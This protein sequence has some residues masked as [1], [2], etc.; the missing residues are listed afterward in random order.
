MRFL[1]C[2]RVVLFALV[3]LVAGTGV[4]SAAS[5]LL[6]DANTTN[7]RPQAALASLGLAY[8]T[9]GEGNF[10]AV[11]AGGTWDLVIMDV[12]SITPAGGFAGLGEQ[13][14]RAHY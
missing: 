10:N 3:L 14:I 5:I 12:P 13:N 6:Y 1:K 9:A 11:L 7:N 8:T 4:S 2:A